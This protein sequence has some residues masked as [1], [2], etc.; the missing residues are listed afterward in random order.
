[1]HSVEETQRAM[2][3]ALLPL[4]AE[5]RRAFSAEFDARYGEPLAGTASAACAWKIACTKLLADPMDPIGE[6]W[7]RFTIS[8]LEARSGSPASAASP[9]AS[10]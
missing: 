7:A 5:Q 2:E 3:A 1:M 4:T 6:A 9:P 8:L 10:P